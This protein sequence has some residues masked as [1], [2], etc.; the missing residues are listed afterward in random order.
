MNINIKRKRHREVIPSG[1]F[2]SLLI[3]GILIDSVLSQVITTK[4]TENEINAVIPILK[5]EI[6]GFKQL[7]GDIKTDQDAHKALFEAIKSGKTDPL[8]WLKQHSKYIIVPPEAVYEPAVSRAVSI[9]GWDMP[10]M[11]EAG[12]NARYNVVPTA[13]FTFGKEIHAI[14]KHLLG[15]KITF[16]SYQRFLENTFKMDDPSY[17]DIRGILDKV[18]S[19]YS[20]KGFST[21]YSMS[22]NSVL[23]YPYNAEDEISGVVWQVQFDLFDPTYPDV[24]KNSRSHPMG[25]SIEIKAGDKLMEKVFTPTDTK[26]GT[27]NVNIKNN[28]KKA[29]ITEDRYAEI[30]TALIMARNDS[31][32]PPEESALP[33]F[34]PSTSEEKQIIQEIEIMNK[35]VRLRNDNVKIYLK[36]KAELDPILD[37]LQQ[38]RYGQ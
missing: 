7:E 24:V 16:E 22:G 15:K 23:L 37:V 6:A 27:D 33:D 12:A 9:R 34:T 29:S 32:Y 25:P 36:N 30:K 3:S 5:A 17:P 35:E 20:Q 11:E 13:I 19:F 14:N 2:V 1:F 28:L 21:H 38:Y 4:L 8:D 18:L 10:G 26:V 31:E